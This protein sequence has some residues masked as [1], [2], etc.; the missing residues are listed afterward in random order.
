MPSGLNLL[1]VAHAF[2]LDAELAASAV[3]WS[4]AIVV[5]V[6]AVVAVAS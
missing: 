1:I 3:A 5:A 4:T 6:V 2:R